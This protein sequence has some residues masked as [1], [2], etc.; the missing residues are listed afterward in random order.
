MA[1]T[2]KN[3]VSNHAQASAHIPRALIGQFGPRL[4]QTNFLAHN[5]RIAI[6]WSFSTT[7]VSPPSFARF[8][9]PSFES[10]DR[11]RATKMDDSIDNLLFQFDDALFDDPTFNEFNCPL[12]QDGPDLIQGSPDALDEAINKLLAS[13]SCLSPTNLAVTDIGFMQI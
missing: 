6:F 11:A 12:P 13:G 8:Q 1:C 7:H 5:A 4:Q 10:L 3:N 2:N 9:Q